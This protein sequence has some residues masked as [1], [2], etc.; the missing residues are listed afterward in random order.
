MTFSDD[1]LD[2][3]SYAPG[4][5]GPTFSLVS[6]CFGATPTHVAFRADQAE[7]IRFAAGKTPLID[8]TEPNRLSCF[9]NRGDGASYQL[10]HA[11][12]TVDEFCVAPGVCPI[13]MFAAILIANANMTVLE[14]APID[15][16]PITPRV[17]RHT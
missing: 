11:H 16:C 9:F 1:D 4:D 7:D 12:D 15:L 5:F 10:G 17:P 13:W 8:R 6:C 14:N 2:E 3:P